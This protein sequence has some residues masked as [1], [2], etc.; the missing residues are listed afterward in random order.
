MRSSIYV[1]IVIIFRCFEID[2]EKVDS[3]LRSRCCMIKVF[4]C[5]LIKWILCRLVNNFLVVRDICKVVNIVW[6]NKKIKNI[7]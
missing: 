6:G 7:F 3:M 4:S 2:E 1:F 5:E